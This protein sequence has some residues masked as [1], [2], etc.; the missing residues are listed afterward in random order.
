MCTI[1]YVLSNKLKMN[2]IQYNNKYY[3]YLCVVRK[4]T[5]YASKKQ[6]EWQR[7]MQFLEPAQDY[8]EQ[9]FQYS[10]NDDS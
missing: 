9:Y 6:Y 5:N 8:G 1:I 3:A 7:T 10:E 2:N 4:G